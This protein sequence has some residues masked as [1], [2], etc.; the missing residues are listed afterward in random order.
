MVM[1]RRLFG[2]LG[3]IGRVIAVVLWRLTGLNY[4]GPM[5]LDHHGLQILLMAVVVFTLVI[6]GPE[7]GAALSAVA[8]RRC[9]WRLGWKTCCRSWRRV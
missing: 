1:A 7:P 3:R 4:F 6:D 2:P 9:R 8:R 5:V